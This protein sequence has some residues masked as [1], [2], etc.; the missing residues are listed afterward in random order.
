MPTYRPV[1]PS[2]N[3]HKTAGNT[4]SPT[5]SS[6]Q[7]QSAPDHRGPQLIAPMPMSRPIT[8]TRN[9]GVTPRNTTSTTANRVWRQR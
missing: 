2:R 7:R 1:T 9:S 4:A 3:S 8:L 6:V 5:A